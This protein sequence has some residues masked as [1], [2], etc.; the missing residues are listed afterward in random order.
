MTS[1]FDPSAFLSRRDV[2]GAAAGMAALAAATNQPAPAAD[3]PAAPAPAK[4]S[5]CRKSINLWAFPY[6]QKMSL[7]QC[8]RLAKDAGFDAVELNYDLESDLS[9]KHGTADFQK[10]RKMADAIG[11]AIS[12]LCSFLFWPYP[13]TSNDAAKRQR[14]LELAGKIAECAHDLGVENVLVVP[15][16]VCIPWRTDHE[17]VPNDV[18]LKRAREAVG[19]LLPGAEKLGVK[20]N[21]ENIFFNGFLM[22]PQEMNDFVDSFGSEHVK[23]HFDT[24]NIM[25]YQYPEH[26][27]RMLGKRDGGTRRLAV[28]GKGKAAQRAV[29]RQAGGIFG[30]LAGTGMGIDPQHMQR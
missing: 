4:R 8:L 29:A 15:G 27:I 30:T 28:F 16:A 6:P 23:V 19:K 25:M 9:P 14:G 1:P 13:L 21:M 26:W 12:G 5:P 22:T 7:E 3:G 2:L 10:I 18:C 17:P 11:I 24:G 20:L